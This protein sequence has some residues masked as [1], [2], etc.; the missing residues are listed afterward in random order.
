MHQYDLVL[1]KTKLNRT[2]AQFD[3][4]KNILVF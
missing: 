1:L 4:V 2:D 3:L